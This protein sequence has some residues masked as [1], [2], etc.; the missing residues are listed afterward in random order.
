MERTTTGETGQVSGQ[1]AEVYE[2]FFVPALFAQW[3]DRTL[4]LAGVT[5]GDRVLDVGCG[6]GVLARAAVPRAGASGRVCAVDPNEGMRAVA[7]RRSPGVE[8]VAGSAEELPFGDDAFDR[9]LCQFALMFFTDRSAGL[10]E[11][12]RVLRPGGRLVVLTWAAIETSPG[13]AAMV[14]LL[15]RLFGDGPADAL[16]APFGIGHPDH[17]AEIVGRSF[18][19]VQVERLDGEARFPSVDAWVR[20]DIKGWTLRDLIDDRQ[21]ALLEREAARELAGFAVD[22]TRVSFPP[23]AL[24]AHA[25]R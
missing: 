21:L 19:D 7:S 24:T 14:A 11:M 2:E 9:V 25:T 5:P 22:G 6:T 13:Y 3:T 23:P 17:L 10:R 1:A 15:R 4:D 8:V 20:T 16:L 18:P 12:A